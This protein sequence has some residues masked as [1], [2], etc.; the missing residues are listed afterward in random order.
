MWRPPTQW[1]LPRKS[2]H[3]FLPGT[4]TECRAY[5]KVAAGNTCDSVRKTTGISTGSFFKFNG[6]LHKNCDNLW[7]GY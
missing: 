2:T 6:G 5:H 7:V 3:H 1:T 4:S